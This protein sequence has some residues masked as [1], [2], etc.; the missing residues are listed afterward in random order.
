MEIEIF[1]IEPGRWAYKAVGIY[2]E[3]H[4]EK[5]GFVSMTEDEARYFAALLEARMT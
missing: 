3:W 4:P 1:E 2:Q 5:E